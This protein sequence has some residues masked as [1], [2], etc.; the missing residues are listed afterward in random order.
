MPL[1]GA[2]GDEAIMSLR[3]DVVPVAISYIIVRL[4]RRLMP[5]RNDKSDGS[6]RGRLLFLSSRGRQAVAISFTLM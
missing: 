1:R 4:L 5:A 6:S 3:G 2:V